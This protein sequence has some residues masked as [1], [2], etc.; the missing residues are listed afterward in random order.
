MPAPCL[1]YSSF[2]AHVTGSE[3]Q[4]P[5]LPAEAA[6]EFPLSRMT[7]LTL[8]PCR[9]FPQPRKHEADLEYGTVRR[10]LA[11]D[12]ASGQVVEGAKNGPVDTSGCHKHPSCT[13]QQGALD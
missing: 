8:C 9:T 10:S 12:L 7:W 11:Q 2:A 4:L 13:M 6:G 5:S 1:H 3:L